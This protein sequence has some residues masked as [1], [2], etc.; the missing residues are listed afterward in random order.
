MQF[1]AFSP[2]K[3]R[4]TQFLKFRCFHKLETSITREPQVQ[5]LSTSISLKNILRRNVYSDSF[6]DIAVQM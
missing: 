6:Q 2:R 4:K 5:S 1:S 3:N